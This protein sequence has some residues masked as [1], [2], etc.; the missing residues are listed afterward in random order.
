MDERGN[1]QGAGP[2]KAGGVL[3]A[4]LE[5]AV[6]REA[7]TTARSDVY[8]GAGWIVFGLLIVVASL[9]MD[10]FTSMGASL[11]MMPGFVPGIP[12]VP[13][14]IPGNVMPMICGFSESKRLTT[15]IGI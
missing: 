14:G 12:G 7:I 4:G 13:S 1:E 15:S 10:R 2:S 8:G 11:Y 5:A 9:R 3:L 6:E